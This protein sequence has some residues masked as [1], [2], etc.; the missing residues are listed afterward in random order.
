MDITATAEWEAL[1]SHRR[2]LEGVHLRDLFA[3][4]PRRGPSLSRQVSDLYVDYSKNRVTPETLRLLI[5]LAERAELGARIDDLFSGRRVNFT[6]DRPALHMAL[7]APAGSSLVVDGQDVVA[8]AHAVLARMTAFAESVRSGEWRGHTGLP[9]ST[10]VN[11][12]IGGSHLGPAMAYEALRDFA[13]DSL[14][15]RFVSNVD[16]ADLE[17]AVADLDPAT[18]LFIVCSKTFSTLETLHNARRARDWLLSALGDPAAVARHFVAVSSEIGRVTEFGIDKTSAFEIWDW[19]GGRYSF[20]SAVGLSLVLTLGPERFLEMLA[21]FRAVDEHFASAPTEANLPALLGLIGIWNRNFLGSQAH[22]VV[23]YSHHLRLFPA[24]LQQLD[25]ESN[26]KSVDREGRRVT[27]DTGPVVWGTAGTNGQHAYFQLLHQGTTVVPADFIGFCRSPHGDTG[28]HDL[29]MANL[30]A[31]T[32]AL[33]FGRAQEEVAAQ[34]VSE[35]LVT[36][37]SFEGNR[38]TTTILAT[39]LSPR[40]LGELVALYEHKVFVQGVIW[41]VNS[42]DQWGVELGKALAG[43]I[44]EDLSEPA[45]AALG[46]DSSTNE[47][48]ERYRNCRTTGNFG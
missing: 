34:G 2:Q 19:V 3:S 15:A 44:A 24:Y 31:Q 4:D 25:M 14:Q 11:I 18:T 46:H 26:G 1:E 38:P 40:T 33:A 32:E 20:D 43:R 29:L 39:E 42:F 7:R 10:V 36:H 8:Q 27:A 23:P 22:A 9:I 21:G 41:G 6:E 48:I 12:G 16:A 5:A 28:T 47:M 13:S 45:G 17:E 30:F 35:E 37:R